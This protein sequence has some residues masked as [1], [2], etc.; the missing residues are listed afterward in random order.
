MKRLVLI[1]SVDEA[2]AYFA[3]HRN[4]PASCTDDVVLSFHPTFGAILDT[5]GIR[6]VNTLRISRIHHMKGSLKRPNG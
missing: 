6:S 3:V 4:D 2:K 1:D 5:A